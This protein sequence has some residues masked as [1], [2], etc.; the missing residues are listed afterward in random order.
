MRRTLEQDFLCD[1]LKGRIRYF[2]TRYRRAHDQTG[3]VCILV[4]DVEIINMPFETEHALSCET[5]RRK[6]GSGKSFNE[7]YAEVSQEFHEQ[8]RFEP[9]DFSVA[10]D[11][12]MS[13]DVQDAIQSDNLLVR[14]FA[15][16]DR[17]IGKRTLEKM[18]ADMSDTPDWLM[19]FYKL[20]LESEG[21]L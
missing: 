11:E 4:D 18:R 5:Q 14:L 3:R 15:I 7:L 9:Y 16:L 12:F 21:M 10:F 8:G 13:S 2:S 20:R 6:P 19:Y 1:S 17:R